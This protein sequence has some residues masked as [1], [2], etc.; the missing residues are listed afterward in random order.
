MKRSIPVIGYFGP[1]LDAQYQIVLWNGIERAA[2]ERGCRLVCFPGE[3]LDSGENYEYQANI[4]YR[5]AGARNVDGL[6]ILTTAIGTFPSL[7]QIADFCSSYAPVPVVSV[8]LVVPGI[9]SVAIDNEKGMTELATHLVARH[10]YRHFAFIAG[11]ATHQEAEKRLE[12]FEKV[13]GSQGIGLDRRLVKYGD[14]TGESGAGACEAL[15]REGLFVDAIVAANDYMAKGALDTL[16][17]HSIRVPDEIALAGFDDISQSAF[18][19]PPLSTV[20]YPTFEEGRAAC[21]L[22]LDIMEGKKTADRLTLPS[23]VRIRESCGCFGFASGHELC[24]PADDR[25]ARVDADGESTVERASEEILETIGHL[26][27]SGTPQFETEKL[28]SLI[29][30]FQADI[31][32]GKSNLFIP[33]LNGVLSRSM[34]E[35][36]DIGEWYS[37]VIALGK[38]MHGLHLPPESEERLRSL[39]EKALM[40]IGEKSRRLEG[41]KRIESDRLFQQLRDIGNDLITCFDLDKLKEKIV[42][43]VERLSIGSC[44]LSLYEPDDFP[45]NS[46]LV[47]AYRDRKRLDT[48]ESGIRF[49]TCELVPDSVLPEGIKGHVIVEPLY[50][51]EDQLGF[52]LFEMSACDTR[53]YDSLSQ[54]LSGALKG[55]FLMA[56][57]NSHALD[58]E[59]EVTERTSQLSESN[60]KLKEEIQQRKKADAALRVSEKNFSKITEA[61]PIPLVLVR[62]SDGRILYCN[63]K[64]ETMFGVN[65]KTKKKP[66][67]RD[68]FK[69]PD[70]VDQ[71]FGKIGKKSQLGAVEITASKGTGSTFSLIA[72]LSPLNYCGEKGVLAGLYDITERKR[73]EREIL[74]IS[75]REQRRIGQD[76]HDDLCQ[77]LA[78]IAVMLSALEKNISGKDRKLGKK[79]SEISAHLNDTIVRTR[80]IARGLYPAALEENGLSYMLAE[81]ASGIN[82]RHGIEC[83]YAADE[84]R[85]IDNSVSLQLYR[86]AQEA[87][88][89]SIRHGKPSKIEIELVSNAKEVVL[90]VADNGCGIAHD[91]GGAKGMGLRIMNYRANI[92]GAKLDIGECTSGGV[93][94]ACILKRK[95]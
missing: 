4:L 21:N 1:Q 50:F 83:T 15:L 90:K 17:K 10:G 31:G 86:I 19:N 3:R 12:T 56:E 70:Y 85:P 28:P 9:P 92:I 47:L 33:G 45:Y 79:A 18:F 71:L 75:G 84:H 32:E 91:N 44:Y 88:N 69:D 5:L 37:V 74:E 27:L 57:K 73:L 68:F 29:E 60:A 62:K 87:I 49:P 94:L 80:S 52:I 77:N 64:F 20:F 61:V 65:G 14:F 23:K 81:L 24:V 11:P 7:S 78:G 53:V 72:S 54:Q 34:D 55:A 43:S 67:I 48:G 93:S 16:K 46:R 30:C 51:Q 89:N 40:L 25:P 26:D 36:R 66:L 95:G 38:G 59:A 58:L 35:D 13:L 41:L 6:I 76:L 42:D 63:K 8:G 2:K 82:E 39:T 22:L